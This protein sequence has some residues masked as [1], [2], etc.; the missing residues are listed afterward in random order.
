MTS[1]QQRSGVVVVCKTLLMESALSLMRK[2]GKQ[3]GS[4]WS[5]HCVV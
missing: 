2:E 1:E 3:E 4:K 5:V